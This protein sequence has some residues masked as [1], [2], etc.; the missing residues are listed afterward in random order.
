MGIFIKKSYKINLVPNY[1]V[2]FTLVQ[3]L[4]RNI[5]LGAFAKY[6]LFTSH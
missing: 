3:L 6:S 2:K 4:Q 1:W 5:Q